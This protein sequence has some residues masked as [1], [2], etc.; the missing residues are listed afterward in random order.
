VLLSEGSTRSKLLSL[1]SP[2][3]P[4]CLFAPKGQNWLLSCLLS[5]AN[6][7]YAFLSHQGEIEASNTFFIWAQLQSKTFFI[8]SFLSHPF[9]FTLSISPFLSLAYLH[10]RGKRASKEGWLRPD[11]RLTAHKKQARDRCL[12]RISCEAKP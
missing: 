2:F 4:S 11:K 7:A 3:A 5:L 6:L 12:L 8:L 1:A 10:R 9:Y